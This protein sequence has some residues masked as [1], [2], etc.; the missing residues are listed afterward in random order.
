M[1]VGPA[2]NKRRATLNENSPFMAMKGENREGA[3]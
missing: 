1:N 2:L 3:E